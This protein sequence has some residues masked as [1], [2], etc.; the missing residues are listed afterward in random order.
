M[1]SSPTQYVNIEEWPSARYNLRS[2]TSAMRVSSTA[3]R[4]QSR[5]ERIRWI[6]ASFFCLVPNRAHGRA[7]VARPAGGR[8]SLGAASNPA[9]SGEPPPMSKLIDVL[10]LLALPASGKSEVRRYLASLSVEQCKDE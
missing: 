5:A 9:R 4:S 1:R 3:R 10:L 6:A 7:S 8:Y 2:S